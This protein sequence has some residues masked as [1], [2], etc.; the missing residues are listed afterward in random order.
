MKEGREDL[1]HLP[2][3][4]IDPEDARDHDDAVW[5]ERG[6]R[7]A[8]GYRAWIAIADVSTY[9]T[10]GTAID[11]EAKARGCSVYLPDRAIPMLPRALSS[12]LCSLLP[13]VDRLCLCV[14]VELDADGHVVKSRLVRGLMRSAGEAHLRRRRPRA[15]PV[16]RGEARAGRPTRWSRACASRYELSRTCAPGA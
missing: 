15:R 2:L 10:P 4:T 11:E 16:E 14:E 12:N 5:V 3:P 6:P 1:R 7:W 9:V 13:D 8:A